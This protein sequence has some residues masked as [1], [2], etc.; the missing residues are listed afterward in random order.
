VG[1][2]EDIWEQATN[3]RSKQAHSFVYSVRLYQEQQ[4]AKSAGGFTLSPMLEA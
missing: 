2:V 3:I 4:T 1:N